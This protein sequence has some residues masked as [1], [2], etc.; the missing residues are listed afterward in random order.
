MVLGCF[1]GAFRTAIEI[2]SSL[3]LELFLL[4]IA[5]DYISVCTRPKH[6]HAS[7]VT[8]GSDPAKFGR[9]KAVRT[10]SLPPDPDVLAACPF[11]F[12]FLA[13]RYFSVVCLGCAPK[14][15]PKG[16][17][18]VV[19]GRSFT[20]FFESAA[21]GLRGRASKRAAWPSTSSASN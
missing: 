20:G 15:D 19:S 21:I 18:R 11:A 10:G 1:G 16:V 7:C 9:L 6:G 17:L 12:L 14:S 4:R 3:P 8:G 2:L 5:V 13:S